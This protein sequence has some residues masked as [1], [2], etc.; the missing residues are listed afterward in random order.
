[1]HDRAYNVVRNEDVVSEILRD[2]KP[3]AGLESIPVSQTL[4]RIS[5]TTL[6]NIMSRLHEYAISKT[7]V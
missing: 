4:R 3:S 2:L 5:T 7:S 6:I 1:M